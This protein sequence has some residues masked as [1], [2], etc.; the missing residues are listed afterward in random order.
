MAKSKK[1]FKPTPE[2]VK[3]ANDLFVEAYP[4]AAEYKEKLNLPWAL[5]RYVKTLPE[6]GRNVFKGTSFYSQK[7]EQS[8]KSRISTVML[9]YVK[10]YNDT[11]LDTYKFSGFY[12]DEL[13]ENI[14][15]KFEEWMSWDNWGEWHIDHIVP[16]H[17]YRRTK[18]RSVFGLDNLRPISKQQN[19]KKGGKCLGK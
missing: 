19:Q 6:E 1:E 17:T 2:E 7:K 11:D 3:F 13:I 18:D 4:Y 8:L 5:R 12:P 16:R 15:S 14:E 10:P 9:Q